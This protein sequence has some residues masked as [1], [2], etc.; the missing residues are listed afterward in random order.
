MVFVIAV[1]GPGGSPKEFFQMYY[2]IVK[3]QAICTHLL[4]SARG[5]HNLRDKDRKGVMSVEPA[6]QFVVFVDPIAL[7]KTPEGLKPVAR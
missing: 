4:I 3:L 1:Q 7:I 2:G 6:D 5:G